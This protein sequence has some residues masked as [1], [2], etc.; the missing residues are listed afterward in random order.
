MSPTSASFASLLYTL[1]ETRAFI[2]S[3]LCVPVPLTT[4]KKKKAMSMDMNSLEKKEKVDVHC[5]YG[6]IFHSTL[7]QVS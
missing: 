1:T 2:R 7:T 4:Y 6:V 5:L 3:L